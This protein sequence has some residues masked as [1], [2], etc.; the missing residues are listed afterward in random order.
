MVG[1]IEVV[2]REPKRFGEAESGFRDEENEP[3]PTCLI[4]KI[5]ISEH[6]VQLELVE[7]LHFFDAWLLAFDND[8]ACRITGNESFINGIE[9]GAFDLVMKIHGGLALMMLRVTVNELLIG[10]AIHIGKS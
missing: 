7:I 1:E 9:N 3:I 2:G 8:F 10:G 5:K 4:A 6:S